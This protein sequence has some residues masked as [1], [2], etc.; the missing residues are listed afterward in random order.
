ME[1]VSR[2]LWR[3][4]WQGGEALAEIAHQPVMG[5][6]SLRRKL[7][8]EMKETPLK[9][10]CYLGGRKEPQ[11][12]LKCYQRADTATMK[13][14]LA[15]RTRLVSVSIYFSWCAFGHRNWPLLVKARE[16][17]K[18]SRA[19][20]AM[21]DFALRSVGQGGVEPLTSRLSVMRWRFLR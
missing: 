21:R 18:P 20:I 13:K 8:T 19:G 11:T 1:P 4:W 14:A 3:D 16:K 9:D 5:W 7:A 6:H 15:N 12:I 10:L 2:H 17:A